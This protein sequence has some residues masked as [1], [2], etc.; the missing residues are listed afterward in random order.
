MIAG[1]G[2]H[3]IL[4]MDAGNSNIILGVYDQDKLVYHWRMETDPR[5]TEDEYAMQVKSFFTHEAFHLN[6]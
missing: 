6:K 2:S 4:V 1:G 5:K 3:M